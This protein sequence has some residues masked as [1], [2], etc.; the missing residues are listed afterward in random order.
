VLRG[1][2]YRILSAISV[3]ALSLSSSTLCT[4]RGRVS[5]ETHTP[6]SG[7]LLILEKPDGRVIRTVTNLQGEFRIDLTDEG[8]YVL[9]VE[10]EGFFPIERRVIPVSQ[11][12][13]ELELRLDRIEEVHESIEVTAAPP[14]IDM[15]TT[16]ASTSV[17]GT[18]IMNVP[19]RNTNDLRSALRIVPGVVRDQ[20]GGLHINGGAEDQVMYT[21]NG[22]N[23][24]DPLTGRFESRL[25]VESVQSVEIT[26]G[27]LA[28]EFGK[29]SAGTMAVQTRTGDDKLRYSATNFVPGFENRK[30]F[31]IGGWTPRLNLSGPIRRGRA[32]FS[33]SFDTQYIKTVIEDL[34][35]GE[36]RI[37]AWRLS[38]LLHTQVNL[39]PSQILYTG[40]LAN[41][42]TAPRTGLSVLDPLETTVDRRSRQWFFHVKDQ[43]YLTSRA[44]VEF[45]FAANRTF[46]REIPQGQELYALTPFGKHGNFFSDAIREAGREQW[47]ANTFLPSFRAHGHHQFKA[48]VDFNR[49]SYSQN[50]RRTGY[51]NFDEAGKRLR[52]TMFGGNGRLERSNYESAAFLQDSWRV[53]PSLLVEAGLRADWDQILG[54]WDASPRVGVAWSPPGMENTRIQGGF[55][56][57]FDAS[58]LRLFTRPLDQYS[59]SWY[60]DPTG[61]LVRGPATSVFTIRNP[62]L[63]R[64]RYQNWNVGWDQRFS[65]NVAAQ[66]QFLRR[67][68]R[69][70]FTYR[71]SL[72]PVA[73]PPPE[74]V[75]EFQSPVFDAIYDLCNER[76]DAYDSFTVS[77][78][79][80]I[81]RQYEW[82]V[83]YTRSRALS[84]TVVDVTVDDPVI[85]TNNVGSMPWDAPNRL[86]SWGYLP[87]LWK[88]W[89][90]AY[91][92][93]ARNGF[94][95]SLYSDQG[96]SLGQV[97][98]HRFPTFFEAN[99]HLERRFTFRKH[100]WALRFGAN[101]ITDR[102]NPD[103]V[104]SVVT[105]SR[106]LTFYGGTGRST[107]FRIR[108]LGRQ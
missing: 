3:V 24:T 8:E 47:M 103:T 96:Y 107:N 20:R 92:M 74:F 51:E 21:L 45:G 108:W 6:I 69:K 77:V 30:G 81:R 39:T 63:A 46:G 32:W 26:S 49:V 56:R 99:L 68:G 16:A 98:S 105:S 42:W 80:N 100:R 53:R 71:N 79:H 7:A 84:N 66:F 95:F 65:P 50:V 40:F 97:N 61:S 29:G 94:P 83:S 15:D 104:N 34:P 101:N 14:T 13:A 106:Y 70:G 72:D 90:V 35:Q 28:A 48:G 18:E 86:L 9:S 52:R 54:R 17:T 85:I 76:V 78:R 75:Q 88:N 73:G 38:N 11:Q 82:M 62:S 5:S 22:F 23:L 55:A 89:A 2:G 87:T 43:V 19:Y 59:I 41:F 102:R 27:N 31:Y 67:R 4:L 57:I 93:E 58:N 36:D 1:I 64:P 10:R 25:S 60:Y 33:N 44:L 91:L 12:G 37:S